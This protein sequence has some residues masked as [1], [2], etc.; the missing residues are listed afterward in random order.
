M[1]LEI[2]GI[3]KSGIPPD[4]IQKEHETSAKQDKGQIIS[5]VKTI[6][7]EQIRD[8][9]DKL[10]RT[11]SIFNKR[12]KLYVNRE[13]NRVI[14]KVIDRTTDKVIR[15]IPPEEIQHLIAR[16]RETIGVL[17]DKEI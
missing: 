2:P 1:S 3:L 7:N 10:E 14:I 8:A 11:S 15:E 13:I 16:I 4:L 5:Q 9:I 12:L 17:V 6:T